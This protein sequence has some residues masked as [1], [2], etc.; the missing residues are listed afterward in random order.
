M[1]VR[2]G[3]RHYYTLQEKL[4]IVEQA[5]LFPRNVKPT[6]RAYSVEAKQIRKWK[7][8][9]EAVENPP[10][11]YPAPRTV[12]ERSDIKNLKVKKSWHKG[13][14]STVSHR[15]K[16]YIIFM[17]E[18]YRE[19]GIC[20]SAKMLALDA[21][22]EFPDLRPVPETHLRRRILL[23]LKKEE[24]IT[25]RRI[26]H[27]AQ[28]VRHY[29]DIVNDF[30][31]YFNRQIVAG[32]YRAPCIVNMDETN[33]D[34]DVTPR[35]TLERIGPR[36]VSGYR[37]DHAARATV[38]LAVT[39]SGVKLPAFVI[40]KGV[41]QGRIWQEV[42]GLHFPRE[43]VRYSVQPKAWQDIS[44]YKDWV[45][46]VVAPY[47]DGRPGIVLQDNFSVHL[48]NTAMRS[49]NDVGIQAEFLPA[50]YTAVL[51]P[52]DKG[53][54]KPFKDYYYELQNNWIISHAE[55]QK[56][57]RLDVAT[58]I[59]TAWNSVTVQSITNTWESINFLP[60]IDR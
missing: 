28:N 31:T 6:A 8:Q 14:P 12:E 50:G 44:T 17:F 46:Q 51:Q 22:R 42:R 16:N 5:Y 23:F 9:F 39:M 21:M 57:T 29:Q 60:Y 38:V 58:W 32:K 20:V 48:N 45:S 34:F 37:V 13:R 47:F 10:P 7:A 11:I 54:I 26:T 49:L 1:Y 3:K 40:F 24:F 18:I 33:L 19:R 43:F 55:G 35:K 15:I 4:N 41:R 56:P 25:H 53:I 27:M 30:V 36:T 52:L 59:N 2:T